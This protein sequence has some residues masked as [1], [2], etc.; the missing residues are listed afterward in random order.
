M[1]SV[2]GKE[3]SSMFPLIILKDKPKI[4]KA[5]SLTTNDIVVFKKSGR[6][7]AHRLIY[8][9]KNKKHYI[10]KGDN[11]LEAD[12]KIK[13][14]QILGKV[15][16]I[17]RRGQKIQIGHLYLSQSINYLRQLEKINS[18]FTKQKI[19]YI[20]LKGLPLHL[21]FSKTPP[22]RLYFDAD[23]LIKSA[24]LAKAGKILKKLDFKKVPTTLFK[25]P[26]KTTSQISFYKDTKPF[27]VII[28][29]HLEPAIAFTKVRSL[30]SL[31]PETKTFNSHLFQNIRRVKINNTYFP[32][33]KTEILIIY[34]LLHFYHHNFNGIHRLELINK[35]ISKRKV[36][37]NSVGELAKRFKFE[38]LIYPGFLMLSKYYKT[39]IPERLLK[40]T[41][42]SFSQ[43]LIGLTISGLIS[44]FNS[45]T[46][47]VEGIKRFVFL[48]LL[49][50]APIAQKL[51]LV[52]QKETLSYYWPSIKSLLLS[53]DTKPS[54]SV[55]A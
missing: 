13:K 33:L 3:P 28:D 12:G 17:D 47:T 34:L 16:E 42:P 37:W 48:I 35:I 25:G 39:K 7:M 19:T 44:P 53:S 29:L 46:R 6:L 4:I 36:N 15:E 18:Q 2:S 49:S 5:T 54:K 9:S 45:G 55:L 31:L 26:I 40:A 50:P 32:I 22:K 52:F 11:S 10:I 20:T 21:H 23:L 8:L 27:E 24:D 30:N 51:K 41:T 43:K 14:S 1:E 38:S